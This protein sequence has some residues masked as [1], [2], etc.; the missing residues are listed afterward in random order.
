MSDYQKYIGQ[1]LYVPAFMTLYL[2]DSPGV[3]S[4]EINH[5]TSQDPNQA[6][7]KIV[8]IKGK[9]RPLGSD[10]IMIGLEDQN[11]TSWVAYTPGKMFINGG[12]PLVFSNDDVT[13]LIA[14]SKTDFMHSANPLSYAASAI[15]D[16][17]GQYKVPVIIGVT[18]LVLS[19]VVKR[20]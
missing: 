20:K 4:K 15:S 7:S 6:I 11:G 5:L 18:L 9:Y 12:A 10:E 13:A 1:N 14:P 8:D 16:A 19:N 17:L 2:Y 3:G